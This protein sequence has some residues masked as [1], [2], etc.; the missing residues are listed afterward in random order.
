MSEGPMHF[1]IR[2]QSKGPDQCCGPHWV[3]VGLSLFSFVAGWKWIRITLM[4]KSVV[5]ISLGK[6]LGPTRGWVANLG[7][8]CSLV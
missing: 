1:S 2:V 6:G 5:T 7:L 3:V 8:L 4:N